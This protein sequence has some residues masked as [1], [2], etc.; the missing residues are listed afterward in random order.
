MVHHFQPGT[1]T[2]GTCMC[3]SIFLLVNKSHYWLGQKRKIAAF[4]VKTSVLYKRNDSVMKTLVFYV[5]GKQL[6]HKIS[7]WTVFS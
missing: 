7:L 4:D 5:N 2:I 1:I 6:N 3:L